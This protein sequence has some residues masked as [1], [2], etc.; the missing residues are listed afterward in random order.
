MCSVEEKML[1]VVLEN[2]MTKDAKGQTFEL[3]LA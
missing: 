2:G 1:K 3:G